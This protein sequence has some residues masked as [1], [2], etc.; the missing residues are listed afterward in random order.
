MPSSYDCEQMDVM[1]PS[2]NMNSHSEFD[3][4]VASFHS[5]L[6][7]FKEPSCV[8]IYST[9]NGMDFLSYGWVYLSSRLHKDMVMI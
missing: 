8:I 6:L 5:S 7:L 9:D 4:S 3:D 2:L 1:R